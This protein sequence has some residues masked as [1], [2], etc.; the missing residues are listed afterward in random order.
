MRTHF[1]L[2]QTE[3]ADFLGISRA[4]LANVEAGRRTL[5]YSAL[6]RLFVLLRWMPAPGGEGPAAPEF[7]AE[8]TAAPDL[9]D[10]DELS[11]RRLYVQAAIAK[12]KLELMG[13]GRRQQTYAR[14]HWALQVLRTG[15][16]TTTA[17]TAPALL[18]MW[19]IAAPHPEEDMLWL[20][21]LA[22]DAADAPEPLTA[23][24]RALRTAR[25]RGLEAERTALDELLGAAPAPA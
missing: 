23:T 22:K 7:T 19:Q 24:E 25:L 8:P 6:Q 9:P 3:L 16:A 4:L 15:L 5:P 18:K 1:A 10:R 13:R 11:Y 2:S 14:R 12:I 21:L 17:P 20:R